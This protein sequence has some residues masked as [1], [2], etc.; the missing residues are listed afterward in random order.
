MAKKHIS[1]IDS[2]LQT[3]IEKMRMELS[4]PSAP[5][6]TAQS[7]NESVERLTMTPERI[8]KAVSMVIAEK[9]KPKASKTGIERG[10]DAKGELNRVGITALIDRNLL[11]DVKIFAVKKGVSMSD[12]INDALNKYLNS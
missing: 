7:V 9:K 3:E 1:R 10:R 8:E 6:P 5:L 4:E 11:E 2:D 12:V